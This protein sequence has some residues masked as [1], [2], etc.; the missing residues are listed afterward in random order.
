[1]HNMQNP[2]SH[3]AAA[4]RNAGHISRELPTMPLLPAYSF[5]TR[6]S[7]ACCEGRITRD[8]GQIIEVD[9][10]D[11]GDLFLDL[12]AAFSGGGGT[13]RMKYRQQ[14]LAEWFKRLGERRAGMRIAS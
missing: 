1:M 5:F 13:G 8:D 7:G 3:I 11:L 6:I 9:G 10:T 12:S 2:I 4:R 14:V